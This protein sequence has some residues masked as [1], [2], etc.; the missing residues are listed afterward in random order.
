MGVR[1]FSIEIVEALAKSATATL[2]ATGYA[3]RVTVRHGDGY[4][5][6][7]EQAPFD[8]VIVTAAPPQ[9]P[10]PLKQQLKVGGRLV[11]PVGRTIQGLR[12][13][14]RTETGFEE[15]AGIPVRFVPMTGRAQQD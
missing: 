7:P 4:V 11:I 5:G 1:V 15:Q 10:E 9:I 8:A 2:A 14:V 3:D 6:W 12:R 13:I